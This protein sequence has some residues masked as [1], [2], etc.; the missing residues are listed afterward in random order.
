MLRNKNLLNVIAG[1]CVLVASGVATW[2]FFPTASAPYR[3]SPVPQTPLVVAIGPFQ[4]NLML[5]LLVVAG[6]A[7]F[8]GMVMALLVRWLSRIAA[9][10]AAAASAAAAPAS[11]K[12]PAAAPAPEAV[13]EKEVP[14]AQKLV[15]WVAILVA[16]G[17]MVVLV[18]Q[19]LPPGFTLF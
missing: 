10:G 19:V 18:W 7:P 5:I 8:A 12:R 1:M 4:V 11:A 9:E 16:V 2:L 14:L 6:G 13:E 17:A 3:P 15:W